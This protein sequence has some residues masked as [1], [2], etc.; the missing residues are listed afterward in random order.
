[1]TNNKIYVLT[2][3]SYSDYHIEAVFST[4]DKALQY[5][6]WYNKEHSAGYFSIHDIEEWDLDPLNPEYIKRKMHLYSVQMWK[7]GTVRQVWAVENFNDI[8]KI[9][10]CEFGKFERPND[11]ILLMETVWAKDKDHAVKIVNEHR[12]QILA[13]NIWNQL[14]DK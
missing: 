14:I 11:P 1:M 12:S 3:G 10:Y 6:E 5:I 13:N 2:E 8:N 7:D 4:E 9:K